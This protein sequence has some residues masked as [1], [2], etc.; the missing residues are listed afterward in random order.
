M[1]SSVKSICV[2]VSVK[3]QTQDTVSAKNLF[4]FSFY[5]RKESYVRCNN[6]HIQSVWV[7]MAVQHAQFLMCGK[8]VCLAGA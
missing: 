2:H 8:G 5:C 1:S 4:Y 7:L 3:M 6:I